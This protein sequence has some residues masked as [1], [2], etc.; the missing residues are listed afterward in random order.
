MLLSSV[1]FALGLALLLFSG[2]LLT[3]ASLR[4]ALL[5]GMRPLT[6]GLTITAF[7]TSAPEAM[8]GIN[9][10][11]QGFTDIMLG[12]VIG[13]NI[14]NIFLVLGLPAF[15]LSLPTNLPTIRRQTAI[16][17][18]TSTLLLACAF[19]GEI[20]F[21]IGIFFLLLILVWLVLSLRSGT[22]GGDPAML[23]MDEDHFIDKQP[24]WITMFVLAIS[25]GGLWGG[26]YLTVRGA[27]GF[28]HLFGL[29]EAVVG[30]T[31]VAIGTSLPELAASVA[32]IWR[33][34][35]DMAIG[36]ILGSNIFNILFVLGAAALIT[37]IEIPRAFLALDLPV[38]L[39]ASA[40]LVPL[41][42][43]H[44]PITRAIGASFLVA[45]GLYLWSLYALRM[46][47]I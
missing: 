18:G 5:L 1:F 24:A 46:D 40:A 36:N 11:F 6:A 20:S 17:L 26:A 10:A 12:N 39:A 37:P 47:M 7:A 14:A 22:T 3:R 19:W 31:L 41:A 44:Y 35:V 16:V 42:L 2:D 15:V 25:V 43:A 21:A 9:A 28:V 32:A 27:E 45:Y 13:S 8:V 30:L 34:H 4:F 38:M 23:A 33:R 29:S